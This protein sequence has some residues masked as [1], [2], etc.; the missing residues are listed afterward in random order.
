[1]EITE[2]RVHLRNEEKLKAFATVTFDNCFVVRNMKIIEGNKGLILC[3][4]SRKLPDGTYKDIAHPI[5][6]PFRK[7]LE[8]RVMAC[9]QEEVK[10]AAMNPGATAARGDDPDPSE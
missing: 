2:I 9:Y 1:M 8:D 10:K 3:M 4:P 6:V 5:N 7:L